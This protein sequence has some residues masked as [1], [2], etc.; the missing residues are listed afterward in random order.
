MLRSNFLIEEK[1][2]NSLKRKRIISLLLCFALLLGMFP[3]QAFAVE[4]EKETVS[5][6]DT[7]PT[8]DST[9]EESNTLGELGGYLAGNALGSAKLYADR[10]FTWPKGFGFAAENGNNIADR[11]K[12]LDASVIGDNNAKNGPDRRIVNRNGTVTWIQTKYYETAV[13][14]VEAAFDGKNYR[15]IVDGKPMQLEVPADQ[16]DDAVRLMQERISNGQLKNCGITDPDEA[17][18][19]VRKGHLT[20][21]QTKNIA[22]AGNVDSLKYDA[23]NGIVSTSC[24][25]GIT[26][27]IDYACCRIN[28]LGA[29]AALKNAVFNGI[30]TGGVVFATYVISSQLAKAGLAGSL[31]K[32]LIPT[33]EAITK[34]FGDDVCNVIMQRIGVQVAG[35]ATANQVANA[36][37]RELIIDGVL[38]VVLTSLDVADLFR[39]KISKEEVLKNLTVTIIGIATGTAGGYGGAV[40]GSLIAPGAGTAVGAILG[41]VAAGGLSVWAA[42]ALIAPYYESDAEEM[43]NIISEEFTILCSDYLIVEDEAD[44]LVDA[45][46]DE[47]VGDVLKDMYAS[48]D[49]HQF[50]RSLIEPLFVSEAEKRDRIVIPTE[51]EIRYGMKTELKGI[52]FIH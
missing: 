45:L 10:K 28:G 4:A 38:V 43:L 37:S 2:D 25:A 51:E 1:E 50:A 20:Y 16:Y 12:G 30:K 17:A 35:K 49:R 9:L 34:A 19:I 44:R 13:G 22:K 7:Q 48:E 24:A 41:S 14:S 15:Y 36:I 32:A 8:L 18:N 33:V 23:R 31:S 42:E 40:L 39:G 52:V 46:K 6:A 3:I 21:E 47:L 26:F 29:E 11:L 5:S 27:V